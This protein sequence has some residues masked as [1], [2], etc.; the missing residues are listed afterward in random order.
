MLKAEKQDIKALS[1][2]IANLRE[3]VEELE[4]T[5]E[6]LKREVGSVSRGRRLL[7]IVIANLAEGVVLVDTEDRIYLCNPAMEEIFG[8][9]PGTLQGRSIREFLSPEMQKVVLEQTAERLKGRKDSY[10]IEISDENYIRK[11]I[12]ISASPRFDNDGKVIGAF[13]IFRDI[14]LRKKTEKE[15]LKLIME[16]QEAIKK[17]KT[18]K[19]LIPICS[20]CKKI[21]D[22]SGFWNRLENYLIEH[23]EAEFTH[24]I[25][26]EC[27]DTVY[28]DDPE[29]E[30]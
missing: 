27:A 21:R 17:I 1:S 18:L 3:H 19:G 7:E 28:R 20:V 10:E 6:R 2:E 24:G 16:L 8:V 5:N 13:G 22:D 23:S 12:Q 11:D 14:T 26:P 25:C 9:K 30:E 15:R 29:D 4:S